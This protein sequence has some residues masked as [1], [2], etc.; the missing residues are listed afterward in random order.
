MNDKATFT[1]KPIKETNRHIN[2]RREDEGTAEQG[3]RSSNLRRLGKEKRES[4]ITLIAGD[5]QYVIDALA[6]T[7]VEN[8]YLYSDI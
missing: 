3:D 4:K 2:V 6:I 5:G 7:T 8:I 1:S